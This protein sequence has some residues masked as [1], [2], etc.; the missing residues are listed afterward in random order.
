MSNGG[1][2]CIATTRNSFPFKGKARM[3]MGFR[4]GAACS[5]RKPIPSPAL[6]LK[7]REQEAAPLQG[8]VVTGPVGPPPGFPTTTLTARRNPAQAANGWPGKRNHASGLC[9]QPS[10]SK[11]PK[12]YDTS[13]GG[14]EWGTKRRPK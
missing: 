2:G 10:L 5:A 1:R 6:P 7:G 9:H 11:Y 8:A 13:R 3:G 14:K 12:K 4:D